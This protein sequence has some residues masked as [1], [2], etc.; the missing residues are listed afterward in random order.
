MA[1]LKSTNITGDLS[2]TGGITVSNIGLIRESSSDDF[3][4][5]YGQSTTSITDLNDCLTPFMG[6]IKFSS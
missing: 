1:Y 5:G 2:V 6:Y 4:L 3:Y